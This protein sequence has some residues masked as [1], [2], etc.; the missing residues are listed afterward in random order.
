MSWLINIFFLF[1]F[2]FLF[3]IVTTCCIVKTIVTL[4]SWLLLLLLLLFFRV[5]DDV[6][7]HFCCLLFY[8]WLV[9]VGY[10]FFLSIGNLN[11]F[12]LGGIKWQ[13]ERTFCFF[14]LGFE[15]FIFLHFWR[16]IKDHWKC[17]N[18][19][20]KFIFLKTWNCVFLY[21]LVLQMCMFFEAEYL[22]K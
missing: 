17:M 21:F 15:I 9:V 13:K 10:T 5:L 20:L 18:Q 11:I 6:C 16:F 1:V 3:L 7:S 19:R 22:K 8:Y 4:A 12:F 2:L 14:F